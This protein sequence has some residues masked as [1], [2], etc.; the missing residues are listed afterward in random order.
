MEASQHASLKGINYFLQHTN[1]LQQEKIIAYQ[2][3]ASQ[4]EISLLQYITQHQIICPTKLAMS[5]AEYFNLPFINLDHIDITSI[6]AA[7]IHDSLIRRYRM[8]PL[9]TDNHVLHIATD[10]PCQY[11]GRKDM[12][13]YTGMHVML[14]IVESHKLNIVINTLLNQKE[15]QDLSNYVHTNE[16]EFNITNIAQQEKQDALDKDEPVVQFIHRMITDAIDQDASDIHF[17]PYERD[18][19]IRYRQDGLLTTI[20]APPYHLCNR[21]AA[22]I[23]VMANLDI[24]E[25]RIPQDGRFQIQLLDKQATDC[26]VSTCPTIHGEKIVVRILDKQKNIPDLNTL[27]MSSEQKHHF[28]QAISK[29]HGMILVTGPT[30]SGKTMTLYAALNHLN[31]IEKNI[32]TA[33]NPVEMSIHGINQININAKTG[34]TFAKTLR[35]FL[36]QDPDIIMIGEMR[37]LET[38]EIAIKAA[39]TGHLVLSTLHTNTAA[40]TIIRLS[41][42]GI[43][44]FN[45]ASSLSLIISQRLVRRLCDTCKIIRTDL[46]T[47]SLSRLGVSELWPSYQATGCNHCT[48]GYRGRMALFEIMPISKQIANLILSGAS[49]IN[50]FNKAQEEG[51]QTMYQSGLMLIRSGLTTFE[52]VHRV[53]VD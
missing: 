40:D 9:Y 10:D 3:Q 30:G 45:I 6:P 19:R 16:K 27:G 38:A 24:S 34:L 41:N 20:A 17:E 21:I 36:R 31:T 1:M 37:D 29:P 7:F 32:S 39:Q 15:Q 44:S 52:E 14:N 35:A 4:A 18:Y 48:R 12:Q 23:K 46:T 47:S 22:R 13:F 42:M 11:Q 2:E 49:A 28:L 33:E 5:L 53:M 26:R 25:R 50:L 51:M 43:Q 8:V